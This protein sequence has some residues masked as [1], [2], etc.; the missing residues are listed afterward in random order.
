IQEAL[1]KGVK[2]THKQKRIVK[3]LQ[4]N[5]MSS[6]PQRGGKRAAAATLPTVEQ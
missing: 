4:A 1:Q 2:L 6:G 5:V 3:K